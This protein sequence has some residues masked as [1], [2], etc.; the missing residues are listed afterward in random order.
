M[1]NNLYIYFL[2][3]VSFFIAI[4]LTFTF[5]YMIYCF[6]KELWQEHLRPYLELF[7]SGEKESFKKVSDL[8][9]QKSIETKIYI[10]RISYYF[11]SGVLLYLPGYFFSE[12]LSNKNTGVAVI[13]GIVGYP[14]LYFLLVFPFGIP[15]LGLTSI[16]VTWLL[17]L[18]FSS[19]KIKDT[20]QYIPFSIVELKEIIPV[21]VWCDDG[22]G[23]KVLYGSLVEKKSLSFQVFRGDHS[24]LQAEISKEFLLRDDGNKFSIG[25]FQQ[26]LEDGF[27]YNERD[28]SKKLYIKKES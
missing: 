10:H 14:L 4:F 26:N 21:E 23:K 9:S 19:K 1:W 18:P 28:P 17:H 12:F 20:N 22:G 2:E 8:L 3:L 7:L 24:L 27:F 6:F 16:G 25:L 11:L 13:F 15:L 5:W